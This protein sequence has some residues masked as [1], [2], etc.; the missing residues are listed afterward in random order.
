MNA[1]EKSCPETELLAR[2]LESSLTAEERA[3]VTSHLAACDEGRRP[4]GAAPS[5][6][7]PPAASVDELLLQ[8]VLGASRRRGNHAP[9]AFAAA[10]VLVAALGLRLLMKEEAPPRST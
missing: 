4:V 2:W 7:A 5:V 6:E 10:A 9:I 1:M 3:R 8:R